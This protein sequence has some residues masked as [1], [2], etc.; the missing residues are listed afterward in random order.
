MEVDAGSL[1][2]AKIFARSTPGT[3]WLGPKQ[4]EALDHLTSEPALKVLL[5]PASSGKS[6][7]LHQFQQQTQD[8]VALPVVGPQQSAIGVLSSLL[9]AVGLGPWNLS[10]IEQRNLLTVFVRQRSLQGKRVSLCVDNTSRFAADAWSEIERLRLVKLAND[11]TLE[12]VVVGTEEDAARAPLFEL[13]HDSAISAVEAVHFL[14]GPSDDDMQSYIDW[15]FTQAGLPNPFSPEA[16]SA[17][18]ALTQGRLNFVNILCQV[19]L[20]EQQ[21]ESM[22]TVDASLVQRA[23][24]VFAAMKPDVPTGDTVR[25]RRLGGEAPES[26]DGLVVSCSGKIVN[27][28]G[29]QGRLLI[30]R[31]PDNDLRLPGRYMSRH[32][33][34]ILPTAEGHYYVIDLNSANGVRVNGRRVDRSPLHDGDVLG[35]GQFRIK[36]EL[37]G[38]ALTEPDLPEAAGETDIVP[39]PGYEEP[40]VR[41]VKR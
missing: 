20:L 12:L 34:A 10:E 23:A 9:T 11:R 6:T 25:I 35:L 7:I 2:P 24:A 5:G 28:V 36:L 16:C 37:K 41:A 15:R 30:G 29:L 1:S 39:V 31:D 32:H 40:V 19:V 26:S 27:T 4:R 3:I 17:V 33:A 8:L 18:N 22:D 21:R 38:R 14:S 13:L